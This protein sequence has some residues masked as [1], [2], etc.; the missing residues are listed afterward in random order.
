MPDEP[1]DPNKYHILTPKMKKIFILIALVFMIIVVP[2][3]SYFYYNFAINR[4][5]QAG[6][7]IGRAHV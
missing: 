7:E 6:R 4:Q 2:A 5:T 3:V 1:L